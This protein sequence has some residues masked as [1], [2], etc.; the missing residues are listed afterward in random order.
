MSS[1]GPLTLVPS[2]FD[3]DG[4]ADADSPVDDRRL[5]AW[6]DSFDSGRE[7]TRA[8]LELLVGDLAGRPDLWQRYVLHDAEQRHYVRLAAGAQAE[9]WLICWCPTQETG[10]HDHAGSRGAVAVVEGTLVETLLAVGGAHPRRE[11]AAGSRFS[12][13][14]AHIHDVQHA[15][16]GASGT[17]VALATLRAIPNAAVTVVE[18]RSQLGRGLAYSTPD[19]RHRLNV[20]RA[21]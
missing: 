2:V 3:R 21:A 11:F 5:A 9:V 20:R 14:A 7:R 6:F 19:P 17:L 8:E 1:H 13:G 18:P 16:G 10:F 15:G 12:F 4:A